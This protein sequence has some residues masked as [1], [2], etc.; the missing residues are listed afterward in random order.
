MTPKQEADTRRDCQTI[1]RRL[2]TI[3]FP[4]DTTR[5]LEL[6]LFRTFAAAR[7]GGLLH[8]SGE[9]ERRPQKRYDDTDLLVSEIIEN[10]CDSPRGAQA[11]ARINVLHGRFRIANEDFLYVLSSFVFEP[12]RWNARFGWRLMT[13]TETLAW[14]WFWRQVGERM[15]IR[16]IPEDYEEFARFSRQYEADNFCCT[17]ASQSVALAT[18]EL[19]AAWFPALLRPLVRNS[20]HALLDPPLLAALA[21]RPAPPWL[22][23]LAEA[24]L[25]TRARLLRWLPKRRQAKLRTQ[26]PRPDY[27]GGYQIESLG[28]PPAARA[29]ETP[30]PGCPFS[31]LN[32]A[33]ER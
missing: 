28:P 13:E 16:D 10:G 1:A 21:L 29:A 11:I 33:T 20:I 12:I 25:R 22:A 5:A 3:T 2:A 31:G 4:W 32:G 7:I 17:A 27:P 9:F 26:V 14:F 30:G 8:A 15:S 24:T 18:R 23:W 19:F 6:A